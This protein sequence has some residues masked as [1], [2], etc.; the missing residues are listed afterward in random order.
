MR[1]LIPL[2]AAFVFTA[3]QTTPKQAP[4]RDVS[5]PPNQSGV[6]ALN[7][8]YTEEDRATA[9]IMMQKNCGNLPVKIKQEGVV[10]SKEWQIAY[11][12]GSSKTKS[13]KK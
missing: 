12:C 5:R 11:D 2:L 3:C 8:K 7:T 4:V 1:I 13:V 10:D 9:D 6:I